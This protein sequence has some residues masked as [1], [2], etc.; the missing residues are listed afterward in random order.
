[1]NDIIHTSVVNSMAI[2]S[3]CGSYR[4]VLKRVWQPKLEVGAFLCENPSKADQLLSD[5]TVFRCGNLA[6]QWGWGGGGV[7]ISVCG[8]VK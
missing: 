4:Y 7:R 6:V 1:M 2:K 8:A 3:E 5:G